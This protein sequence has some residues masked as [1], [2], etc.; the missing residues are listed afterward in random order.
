MKVYYPRKTG[1]GIMTSMYGRGR[2]IHKF[3]RGGELL[4][5]DGLGSS[6]LQGIQI[7]TDHSNSGMSGLGVS[8][9]SERI[10]RNQKLPLQNV[11]DK[12]NKVQIGTSIKKKNVSFV[13]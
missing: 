2:N 3:K 5:S 12:L 7:G 10:D 4:L 8:A 11:M 13:V 6:N 1:R 9:M